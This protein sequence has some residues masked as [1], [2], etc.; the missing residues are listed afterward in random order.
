MWRDTSHKTIEI[1]EKEDTEKEDEG[2]GV[3]MAGGGDGNEIQ[4]KKK[5]KNRTKSGGVT[6]DTTRY[7]GT[8]QK[9]LYML[10]LE[11]IGKQLFLYLNKQVQ[12]VDH[13]E[14][15][16]VEQESSLGQY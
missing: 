11:S 1:K 9:P 16:I 8:Y 15:S 10:H 7:K 2:T 14:I 4:K 12:E 3:R 13:T 6:P 5:T